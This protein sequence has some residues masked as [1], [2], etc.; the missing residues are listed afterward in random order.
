[1]QCKCDGGI[2]AGHSTRISSSG[3]GSGVRTF[4]KA[5]CASSNLSFN[6]SHSAR[7]RYRSLQGRLD[8]VIAMVVVVGVLHVQ[9]HHPIPW[10][11]TLC[12]THLIEIRV[13]L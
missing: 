2:G 7:G 9:L 6:A 11:C 12:H 1:V 13:M 4:L 10:M 8:E 3:G 5:W